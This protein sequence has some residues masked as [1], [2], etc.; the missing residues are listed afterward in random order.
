MS[1]VRGETIYAD[2]LFLPRMLYCRILRS[3]HPHAR[4]LKIDT[5]LAL[6]R[7]GVIAVITG[8]DLPIPY[9]ILPVSQ[10]EEALCVD[11]VRIVGDPV[12]AVAALDE[13]TAEATG[14]TALT[15]VPAQEATKVEAPKVEPAA[16]QAKEGVATAAAT[17]STAVAGAAPPQEVAAAGDDGDDEPEEVK[18]SMRHLSLQCLSGPGF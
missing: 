13:E 14:S 3:T 6:K 12:A 11:K 2:D 1:K 9:G 7:K 4:I 8:K 15:G 17:G 5:A 10:D 18:E 16:S